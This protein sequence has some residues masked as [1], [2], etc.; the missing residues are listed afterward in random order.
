[1]DNFILACEDAG[2]KAINRWK[3]N[4]RINE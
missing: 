3:A 2:V 4:K 1:L